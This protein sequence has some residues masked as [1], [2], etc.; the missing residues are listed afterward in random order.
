MGYAVRTKRYRYVE[1]REWESK[2]VVARELYDHASDANESRNIVDQPA[3]EKTVMRLA[4][5]LES[6]PDSVAPTGI[7]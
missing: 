3:S 7:E 4:K 1:W 5:I 6:G 2:K